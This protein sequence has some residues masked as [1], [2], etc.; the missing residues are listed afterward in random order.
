LTSYLL[1]DHLSYGFLA[2]DLTKYRPNNTHVQNAKPIENPSQ[3][4]ELTSPI[5]LVLADRQR[6]K[7]RS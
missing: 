1:S 2:S 7:L 6:V 3:H 4:P 5:F